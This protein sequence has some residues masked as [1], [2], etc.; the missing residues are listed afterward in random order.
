MGL[1]VAERRALTEQVARRYRSASKQEKA[2]MLG[3]FVE[4][5]SYA[6]STRSIC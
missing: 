4:T 6:R 5:T 2:V 1:T 3:E